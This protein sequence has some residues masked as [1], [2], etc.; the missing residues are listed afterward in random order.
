MSF[1]YSFPNSRSNDLLDSKVLKSVNRVPVYLSSTISDRYLVP[2]R[3]GFRTREFG[4]RLDLDTYYNRSIDGTPLT[5]FPPFGGLGSPSWLPV[6]LRLGSVRSL[7]LVNPPPLLR[8]TRFFRQKFIN[9]STVP[10][11]PNPN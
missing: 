4:R 9:F 3:L 10:H 7:T 1:R 2:V 11:L 8:H 5:P 6:Y